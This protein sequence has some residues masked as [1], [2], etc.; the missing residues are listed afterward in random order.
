MDAPRFD[1]E[2]HLADL[3]APPSAGGPRWPQSTRSVAQLRVSIRYR[4]TGLLAGLTGDQALHLDIVDYPGEWLL[5]LALLPKSF[6]DWSRAA[7]SAAAGRA[8]AS[9]FLEWMRGVDPQGAFEEETAQTGARLYT[10]YLK[11]C[12]Q[13]GLSGLTPGRFLLPG[14]ME[15]APALTF[16]PLPPHSDGAKGSL[17]ASMRERFEAYK[18]VVVRPFFRDHFAR[19]DRQIVLVDALSAIT[20]GPEAV[21]D[22][23]AALTEILGAFRPGANSWLSGL[24][25]RR[26]DRLLLAVSKADHIHHRHHP[27]LQALVRDLLSQSTDRAEFKG[28]EV[29]AIAVAGV[30]AT[31]EMEIRR[32]GES[33]P[34]VEGRLLSGG[35]AQLFP[36]QPPSSLAALAGSDWGSDVFA[37]EPFAPPILESREDEGPPHI[38]L[39]RALEFLI[40]D[41]LA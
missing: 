27:A 8:Q 24:L 36:G 6:D 30:R 17:A 16:A 23:R 28:A 7:L 39:D 20:D 38:R 18:R 21:A 34:V 10:E 40:G 1:Y 12:R 13:A 3:Y 11:A 5:D 2:R 26:V 9:A 31:V 19:L 32:G 37:A 15:G 22:M 14:E 33:L 29:D 41:K 4:P 35:R 25:G